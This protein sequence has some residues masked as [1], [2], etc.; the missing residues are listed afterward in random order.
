MAVLGF[1]AAVV[2]VAQVSAGGYKGPVKIYVGP[3]VRDGFV[4]VDQAVLDSVKDLQLELRKNPAF[5]VV[6]A[7]ADATLKLYVVLRATVPTGS[8][9]ESGTA[10][11]ST[12]GS[13]AQASGFSVST[14]IEAHKLETLQRVGTYERAFIGASVNTWKGSAGA[15]VKDL[16]VWVT[17]NHDRLP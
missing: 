9:V 10:S 3:V 15:V 6:T 13:N 5:K 11:G 14:P 17:A 4:D 8:N 7:E 2:L 1:V 12:T 16:A